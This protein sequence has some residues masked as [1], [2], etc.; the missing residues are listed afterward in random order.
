MKKVDVL[1]LITS[2]Q[3]AGLKSRVHV[4]LRTPMFGKFMK[5]KDSDELDKKGYV[6][7]LS[8]SKF[9]KY[10]EAPS[11]SLTML[12]QHDQITYVINY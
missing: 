4:K 11:E 1:T 12:L 10:E 3:A 9:D 2:A 8:V 6:R 5:L 7:F